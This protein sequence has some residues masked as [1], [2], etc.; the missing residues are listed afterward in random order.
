MPLSFNIMK[1]S[2]LKKWPLISWEPEILISGGLILTLINIHPYINQLKYAL[3]PFQLPGMAA[4][5]VILSSAFGSLTIGFILH[6]ILRSLWLMKM[7]VASAFDTPLDLKSFRFSSRYEKRISKI[8]VRKEAL[9]L[10]KIS[11]LIFSISFFFLLLSIG[12]AV[13]A[14]ILIGLSIYFDIES[15]T[16]PIIYFLFLLLLIDFISF[17]YLKRTQIGKLLYPV[18]YIL[19]FLTL[20]FLYRDVYYHLIQNIKKSILVFGFIL[21]IASSIFIGIINV[22]EAMRWNNS[23]TD[24]RYE[25]YY[26]NIYDDERKPYA[27]RLASISSYYQSKGVLRLFVYGHYHK[28]E[29]ALDNNAFLIKIDGQTISP[30]R[31]KNHTTDE[32]QSGYLMFLNIACFDSGSEHQIEIFTENEELITIPFYRD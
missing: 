4:F 26:P 6:L 19:Y 16:L 29:N 10:G 9:R 30:F 32:M 12:F 18:Y 11:S 20:S 5:L 22:S 7:G 17:G 23:I 3:A 14:S 1:K 31:I 25:Q 24:N 2:S 15:F 13:L 27:R 8:D 28:V 21:F